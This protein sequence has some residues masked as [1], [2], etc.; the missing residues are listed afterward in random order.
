MVKFKVIFF[1]AGGTLIQLRDTTLPL[2]YSR[3][4]SR[5]LLTPV[6]S[7]EIYKAFRKA[8]T[9]TLSRRKPGALFTD[10][11]QRKYQNVFYNHLGISSRKEINRIETKVAD[12]IEMDFV[13]ETGARKLLQN[14]KPKY[15]LGLISNWDETLIDILQNLGILD[16]FDSIT[17][18]GEFGISKPDIEIFRSALED[19]S[20]VKPKETAYIG[21]DYLTDIIPAQ[22]MNIFTILFD[23]GPDGMHG[24]PFQP[25][26]KCIRINELM[27]L[28]KILNKYS[29][30]PKH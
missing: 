16:Y 28:P 7:E 20:E 25:E 14:L 30:N 18:S 5:I 12:L 27:Q 3:L 19:F 22:N 24:R 2:L 6:S 9:W 8:D 17:I 15:K 4:L 29:K 11:D 1:N 23:K 21:D 13:L 10:L 26:A